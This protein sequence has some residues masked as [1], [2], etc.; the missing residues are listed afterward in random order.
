MENKIKLTEYQFFRLLL[1]TMVNEDY[2]SIIQRFAL[3][4][5]L[6][7]Y[8]NKKE[9][10]FLFEDLIMRNQI[11]L[12]SVDLSYAF[13][14]SHASGFI[15]LIDDSSIDMNY[16]ITMNDEI[17]NVVLNTSKEEERTAMS[18]LLNNLNL[19]EKHKTKVKK[20]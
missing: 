5:E 15:S 11:N 16:A 6:F 14:I 8:H 19:K 20:I 2:P 12:R 10:K 4:K 7:K 9:F 3:E 17:A 1:A 13:I 18:N